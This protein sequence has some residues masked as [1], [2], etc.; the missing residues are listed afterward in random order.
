MTQRLLPDLR[1]Y[2]WMTPGAPDHTR[3]YRLRLHT[4][5]H[6]ADTQPLQLPRLNS[7]C[8]SA[9]TCWSNNCKSD[10]FH[11]YIHARGCHM[12]CTS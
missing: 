7:N 5:L 8:G 2:A 6:Y 11:S 1:L 9:G 10:G 3:P 4:G 12:D